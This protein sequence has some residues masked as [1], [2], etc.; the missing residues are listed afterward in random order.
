MHATLPTIFVYYLSF[1][2]FVRT[3]SICWTG[4]QLAYGSFTH[5]NE[6]FPNYPVIV[7]MIHS[8]ERRTVK[9]KNGERYIEIDRK[10]RSEIPM[11]KNKLLEETYPD[12]E[13]LDAWVMTM[14][15]VL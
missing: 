2:V 13:Q 3:Y 11:T 15:N 8:V 5:G 4:E 7:S 6:V 9:D 12:S 10:I 1:C 14:V